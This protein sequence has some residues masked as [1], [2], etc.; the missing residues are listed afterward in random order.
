MKQLPARPKGSGIRGQSGALLGTLLGAGV[1]LVACASSNRDNGVGSGD[2]G[3]S[4]GTTNSSGTGS[5]GGNGS[6][7]STGSSS[8]FNFDATAQVDA[9]VDLDA[10]W[11]NDPPPMWCGPDGGPAPADPGGTPQCPDDKNR[12][13]CPCP[14][15]GATAACWPGL[16][17]NRD[18]G[19]CKDGT[20]TCI[21]L[22]EGQY[23]WGP[24]K[25]YVLP[26][27]GATLGADAC[28]CFSAGQWALANL[29]PCF[30][31]DTGNTVLGVVS[32]YID[33]MGQAQCPTPTNPPAPQPGSTWTTDTLK[34]DCAGH[35]KVCFQL[36]AGTASSPQPTDCAIMAPVCAEGDYTTA[37]VTQPFP[38]LPSWTGSDVACAQKFATTGGYGEMTV[39]GES[40]RCDAVD[41]GQGNPLVFNRVQY[42]PQS[43]SANPTAPGCTNCNQ[44]G[45]GMF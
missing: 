44:G 38:D 27:P 41:D 17:A 19:I 8:G 22:Q 6:S 9:P 18:I 4:S 26:Q 15:P 23:G 32:T 31:V 1:I 24:C 45:S 14:T 29:S 3:G 39:I 10:F 11:A 35:F 20:T 13:G 21:S 12:E 37:N 42:C 36:K 33:S 43:C 7:G 16:R 30:I 28:K 5:S 2:D 25:G 34:A 40:V